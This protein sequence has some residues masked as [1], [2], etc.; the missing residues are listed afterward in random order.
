MEKLEH[1]VLMSRFVSMSEFAR[2]GPRELRKQNHA[3]ARFEFE[4]ESDR[5]V[6]NQIFPRFVPSMCGPARAVPVS[7]PVLTVGNDYCY[8]L[9][10]RSRVQELE[11]MGS[12][13]K[14]NH[15]QKERDKRETSE[16][17][18]QGKE[19]LEWAIN[20]DEGNGIHISRG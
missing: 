11:A 13:D 16:A 3:D 18:G 15:A 10:G 20:K 1:K 4:I 9:A 19:L 14:H 5:V 7:L 2:Q 8:W 6:V 17:M 12:E